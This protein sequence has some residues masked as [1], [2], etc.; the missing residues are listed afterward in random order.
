[1]KNYKYSLSVLVLQA[2]GSFTLLCQL[3]IST[4]QRNQFQRFYKDLLFPLS[5]SI[6]L[7]VLEFSAGYLV[8]MLLINDIAVGWMTAQ[9]TAGKDTLGRLLPCLKNALQV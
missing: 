3:S 5:Y 2:N 8:S 6:L 9:D 4:P 7:F 1:M